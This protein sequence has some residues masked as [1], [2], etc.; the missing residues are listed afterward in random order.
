MWGNRAALA[1][2]IIT[3]ALTSPTTARAVTINACLAGKLTD[4]GKSV[5]ARLAC[6]SRDAI[7][8]NS[9]EL[10]ACLARVDDRFDGGA[11]PASGRFAQRELRSDCVTSGDQSAIAT[12]IGTYVASVKSAVAKSAT[13]NRCDATKLICVGR[14]VAAIESCVARAASSTGTIDQGCLAR[15]RTRLTD[16]LRGCLH[17]AASRGPCSVSGDATALANGADAFAAQTLCALDPSGSQTCPG[18]PT[19]VA[20]PSR[21][22][23][24]IAT[25]TPTPVP[26]GNP[27]D[28]EQLCVDTINAYRATIGRAPLA[29][30][31]A[32]EACAESQGFSDSETQTAHSAFGRCGEWAQNECP[33]WPGPSDV[34]IGNCLAAMWSEGPGTWPAHGHYINMANSSYTKVACGFAVLSDGKV[35]AV[36]DF[37]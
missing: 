16:P 13:S 10:A 9:A 31:T 36:Q 19:P 20:T 22:P 1:A 15:Q 7:E 30:W 32:A 3:A 24:P 23:T 11:D 4:V 6:Q 21:T 14:Y 5:A 25:R 12:R 34:M 27:S 29:R 18:L 17:R 35:W 26:T 37:Q 8:P 2:V 28:V 33:G